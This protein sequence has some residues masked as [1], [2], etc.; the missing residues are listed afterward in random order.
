M[1]VIS[2]YQ[3]MGGLF[4]GP[5]VIQNTA[6]NNEGFKRSL[7]NDV[8]TIR[9]PN[10]EILVPLGTLLNT[11]E[12]IGKVSKHLIAS[13]GSLTSGI[14]VTALPWVAVPYFLQAAGAHMPGDMLIKVSFDFNFDGPWYNGD[15]DGTISVFLF[16]RLD[17][18]HHLQ[19]TLDGTW[20]T[21]QGGLFGT[22]IASDMLKA[23]MPAVK[24]EV[25]KLLAVALE[26]TRNIP[27]ATMYM[28]PGNGVRIPGAFLQDA[29]SD[30]SLGLLVG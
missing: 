27:F 3:F 20:F 8:L 4:N 16:A 11:P 25:N 26:S 1:S 17:G 12:N 14:R 7:D 22:G 6:S 2:K 29:S 24:G 13:H 30:L 21:V 15:I 23:A 10:A 9:R 28:M 5:V 18:S 19:V